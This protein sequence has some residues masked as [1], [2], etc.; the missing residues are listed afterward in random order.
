MVP[1]TPKRTANAAE[2]PPITKKIWRQSMAE[3]TKNA[4]P[5]ADATTAIDSNAIDAW[6]ALQFPDSQWELVASNGEIGKKGKGKG[7]V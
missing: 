4:N 3:V 1:T 7:L 5:K 6:N 2:T